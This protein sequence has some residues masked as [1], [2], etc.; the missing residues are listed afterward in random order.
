MAFF[1]YIS[2]QI[3]PMTQEKDNYGGYHLQ[4]I[5]LVI[6]IVLAMCTGAKAQ[7]TIFFDSQAAFDAYKPP[8][9]KEIDQK[10]V[11]DLIIITKEKPGLLKRA[12]SNTVEDT[13]PDAYIPNGKA[14]IEYREGKREDAERECVK[15]GAIKVADFSDFNMMSVQLPKGISFASFQKS[16][17]ATPYFQ[18]VTEDAIIQG[19]TKFVDD[20]N[21]MFFPG[22]YH[23]KAM[24]VLEA[25]AMLPADK[26]VTAA[27]IDGSG[28]QTGH[29]DLAGMKDLSYNAVNGST[30]VEPGT[31]EKHATCCVGIPSGRANNTIGVTGM[32][33]NHVRYMPVQIGYGTTTGGAFFTSAT[34]LLKGFQAAMDNPNVRVISN[35]WGSSS[36]YT[37]LDALITKITTQA[38]DGKGIVVLA[39]SGNNGMR[40]N[41]QYPAYFTNAL[42]IGATVNGTVGTQLTR[43]SFSNY[44]TKVMFAAPGS[45]IMSTDIMGSGG[46]SSSGD[47]NKA[48][49]HSFSGTSASCPVMAAAFALLSAANDTLNVNDLVKIMAQSCVKPAFYTW[50]PADSK[51]PYSTWSEELGYGVP[52]VQAAVQAAQGYVAPPPPPPKP[53][54]FLSNCTFTGTGKPG[55]VITVSARVNATLSTTPVETE[56]RWSPDGGFQTSDLLIGRVT[57]AP[58][59]VVSLSYTVPSSA[60]GTFYVVSKTDNKGAVTEESET[61]NTCSA[62][63]NTDVPVPTGLDCSLE[64]VKVTWVTDSTAR[65]TFRL[66]KMGSED[67]N[68]ASVKFGIL[69]A[70]NGISSANKLTATSPYIDITTAAVKVPKIGPNTLTARLDKIGGYPTD[71]NSSNNTVT[72]I[73]TRLK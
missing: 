21:D 45:G 52:N 27:L 24:K 5:F 38:R 72:T 47:V 48:K 13:I 63:V 50:F 49:Y 44:G 7:D 67:I 30:N 18:S 28:V 59:D 56:F 3:Q 14:I 57:G 19:E 20:P 22:A 36:A 32:G 53:N 23:L 58:G 9:G 62:A 68:G 2:P 73:I 55:T 33:L 54:Y 43:A 66:R 61:D 37:G 35:S 10:H 16:L 25:V 1:V 4:T 65:Y 71:S 29:D 12:F 60:V 40:N 70:Q 17:M 6:I 51:H 42:S 34:I 41:I 64:F 31:N 26:V 69:P 46:Y 11:P 15:L 8:R 39:S